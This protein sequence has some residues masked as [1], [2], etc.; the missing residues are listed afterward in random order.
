MENKDIMKFHTKIFADEW[1]SEPNVCIGVCE[2]KDSVCIG[3]HR[4]IE[5]IKKQHDY[6]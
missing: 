1:N 4:H 6:K 2:L 5:E 3:C